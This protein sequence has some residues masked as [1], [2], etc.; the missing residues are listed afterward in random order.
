MCKSFYHVV[1][2][3]FYCDVT[4]RSHLQLI[5]TSINNFFS[6]LRVFL[7]I[8]EEEGRP[9]MVKR[10][11]DGA[12]D[13]SFKKFLNATRLYI[14]CDKSGGL[15]LAEPGLMVGWQSSRRNLSEN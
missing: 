12:V 8:K 7:Q 1:L 11:L 2:V 10:K 15:H 5:N 3:K 6:K 13:E 9:M 14:T 4:T